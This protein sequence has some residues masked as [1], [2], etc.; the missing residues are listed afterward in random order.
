VLTRV[1]QAPKIDVE[2]VKSGH[3]PTSVGEPSSTVV[4]PAVTNTIFN[5]VGA[6]ARL[7][8]KPE[9]ASA[10]TPTPGAARETKRLLFA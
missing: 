8:P 7:W 3:Y 5:A 4:A 6:R 9:Q 10:P 2:I 1:R